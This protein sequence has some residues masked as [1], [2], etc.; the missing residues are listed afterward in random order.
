MTFRDRQGKLRNGALT[1]TRMAWGH[2]IPSRE[3][4]RPIKEGHADMNGVRGW[5]II[6]FWPCRAATSEVVHSGRSG[7]SLV[8]TRGVGGRWASLRELGRSLGRARKI[9]REVTRPIRRSLGY[10]RS[11]W[12]GNYSVLAVPGCHLSGRSFRSL[13]PYF[14]WLALEEWKYVQDAGLESP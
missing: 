13:G 6:R 2:T 7:L 1:S 3:V 4:T 12:M 5:A 11:P 14:F 9:T 10:E 8:G